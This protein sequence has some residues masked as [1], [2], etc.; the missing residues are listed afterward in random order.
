MRSNC[1]II[2]VIAFGAFFISG[3]SEEP[4]KTELKNLKEEAVV[5]KHSVKI[6]GVDIP[7]QA[8]AG[9]LLIK[10]DQGRT[11]ASIFYVAYHKDNVEDSSR[12][13][14]TFCFNGGPGSSSVWLHM[15]LFGPK[16][17]VINEKGDT[18]PPIPIVEN[19]YSLLDLTDLVFIDPVSTGYSR[20]AP[21]ED[22]KQFHGV[23]EDIHSIGDFIRLYT[24]KANRW[25]SPKYLA[26]E[27]YGT[28]RA[29]GL[30]TYLHDDHEMYMNGIILISSILNFQTIYEAQGGND[31]PYILSL[32]SF[33]TAAWYH[34][35]LSPVLQKDLGKAL[36]EVKTFA[37]NDYSQ[38]LMHGDNIPKEE[39][40]RVIQK[41]AYYTGLSPE[42]I[43]RCAMRI[44]V[45][46]FTKELL[47][48]QKRTIGRFDSRIIGID[49]DA[50][51]ECTEYDPS[52][53]AIFGAFTVAV[54]SYLR[55]DLK[56]M[57]DEEYVILAKVNPWNYGKACNQFLDVADKLREVVTR[58]SELK[59]FVASGIY[60]LATP[61][62]ATDYT[63][64]H[65]GLDPSLKKQITMHE[66][67]AGH[68][69]YVDRP[70]LIKLKE[71]LT[72]W[73]NKK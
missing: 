57:Q 14:I 23:E 28:T 11:K 56:W 38:A 69:I 46:R 39:R 42:F 18:L 59:V 30:A 45:R 35:K 34:Q 49:S 22:A 50:S 31:L 3:Y 10:D 36:A 53:N 62:Y 15:G 12:R 68:M 8:I 24:T 13:P 52:A 64:N 1:F 58:N 61:F 63:F 60:D 25:D 2:L 54:N 44:S 16:R 48:S 65:L 9:N 43:D 19:D 33:T 71:E 70:S 4:P 41:L 32:P 7:Y 6:N 29:A 66:Y 47:R 27:S 5:T 37:L 40:D 72:D 51:G 55:S 21:G 73:M 20:A 17:L 67:N 26:G